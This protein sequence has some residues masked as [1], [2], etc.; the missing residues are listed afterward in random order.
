LR[1]DS[2]SSHPT[3]GCSRFQVC[4]AGSRVLVRNAEKIGDRDVL[5]DLFPAK[6]DSLVEQLEASTLLDRSGR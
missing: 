2:H 6:L 1:L 5:V 4:Y 3:S